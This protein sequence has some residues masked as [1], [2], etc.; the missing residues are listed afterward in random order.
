[1]RIEGA[2]LQE[3][4]PDHGETAERAHLMSD[5]ERIEKAI[6]FVT[7]RAQAQPTLPEVAEH[8]G[9]S[10]F[11][12]Q[13]MF[14]RWAGVT[15]KRY[16]QI[17]TVERAKVLLRRSVPTFE[18][19]QLVG[20]SSGS[21]L[22]EHFVQLEA[23]TPGQFK[24]GGAGLAIDYAVHDTPFGE[25]FVAQTPRGICQLSFCQDEGMDG[26]LERLRRDWPRAQLRESAAALA[27]VIAHLFQRAQ[28]S[29]R[30]LSLHVS[31]TN[32]QV[33]VWR[34]LL[35]VPPGQVATYGALAAAVGQP[36]AARAVGNAVGA[37]PIAFVIPCHRVIRASGELGGFR[38]GTT[39]K[40]ALH[41]W[42]SAGEE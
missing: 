2:G 38:W 27:P 30:P 20:L 19:S 17:L 5:Y 31:G 10:P 15:P 12:F 3:H 23:V 39:R 14:S 11:H 24:T 21:R 34:A 6:V 33:S 9:L 16:L 22:H 42:E 28:Q 40:Q 1:M 32:F 18:A 35:A 37:N 29:S 13:R 41:A 25:A 26:P 7:Q 8:V 4:A 36:R